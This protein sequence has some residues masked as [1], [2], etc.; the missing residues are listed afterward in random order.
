MN[1]EFSYDPKTA[2]AETKPAPQN[3]F[4]RLVGVYF[5]PGET[6]VGM[7]SAP[8]PLA[9]I[10]ALILLFIISGVVSSS[11]VPFEKIAENQIQQRVASGRISEEQAEQ[12]RQGTK[13]IAPFMKYVIPIG[14]IIWTVVMVFAFAGLAKLVSMVMGAE[15]KYLPLVSVVTYSLLAVYIV[16]SVIFTI[17]LFIKPVDEFDW[18]NPLGSN[19]AALLSAVGVEGLPSFVKS[20]FS[21]VDVFYIWKVAL[22][23]I[24][25]AAV[26]QKIKTSSAMIYAG[27]AA[28]II[29]LIG[30]VFGMLN[31]A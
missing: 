2:D 18:N 28:F 25:G 5:S 17:L 8:S 3:F 29:A 14:S 23:A 22:I 10:I 26:S 1:P 16:S 4:S 31:G 12:Q 24:G 9:P 19:L 6:F 11:R 21:Y 27:F 7:A 15:N 30:A 13:K 20:L